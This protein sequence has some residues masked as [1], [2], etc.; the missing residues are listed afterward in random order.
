ML[1]IELQ[2]G[3]LNLNLFIAMTVLDQRCDNRVKTNL[4]YSYVQSRFE[5]QQVPRLDKSR[6]LQETFQSLIV[7]ALGLIN[8]LSQL[9]P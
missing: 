5:F 6:L 8:G 7:S 2:H 3:C 4:S 9:I 1:A